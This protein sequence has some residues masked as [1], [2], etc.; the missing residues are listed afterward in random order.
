MSS[1]GYIPTQHQSIP[2]GAPGQVPQFN[3]GR[4]LQTDLPPALKNAGIGSMPGGGSVSWDQLL[5]SLNSNRSLDPGVGANLLRQ[6]RFGP[7]LPAPRMQ[8]P[9]SGNPQAA[10]QPPSYDM[11]NQYV[12]S[13]Q[14]RPDLSKRAYK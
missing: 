1:G 4:Q 6:S 14:A 12:M 7:Q 3:G 8:S 13:M 9:Q 11:L 5:A 10:Y 2:A